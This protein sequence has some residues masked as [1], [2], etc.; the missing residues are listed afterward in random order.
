MASRIKIWLLQPRSVAS[1]LLKISLHAPTEKFH[2]IGLFDLY[3][4]SNSQ[5]RQLPS[6]GQCSNIG[7][8][9][10]QCDNGF[11]CL[12]AGNMWLRNDSYMLSRHSSMKSFQLDMYSSLGNLKYK[13]GLIYYCNEVLMN[14]VENCHI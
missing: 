3:T 11:I 13:E 9:M 7:L 6:Q 2:L 8:I 4:S 5:C 14:Q 1:I 12:G 10:S